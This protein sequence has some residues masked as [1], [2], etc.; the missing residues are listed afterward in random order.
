MLE[1]WVK[2]NGPGIPV[3]DQEK[4]F[5][6]FTR[7]NGER[8]TGLG[9]GLAFCKLAVEGHGGEIRVDS[10]ADRGANFIISLPLAGK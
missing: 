3:R 7:L 8:A 1:I 10:D 5:D 9:L 4:I 6:K 2:D